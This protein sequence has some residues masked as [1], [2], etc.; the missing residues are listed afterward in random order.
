MALARENVVLTEIFGA[1]EGAMLRIKQVVLVI[2]GIAALAIAAKIKLPMWP[3]PATLQT[4]VVLSIGA[5]YGLRLGLITMLGYLALGVIG[6]DVFTGSSET[7]FGLSYMMGATGGYLVGFV[8]AAAVMG[9]LARKG[10]D[11]TAPKMA[12][13]MLIGNII[14]YAFGL[15]WMAYLFLEAK[16]MAWVMQ[17]GLTNFIVFDAVKLALAAM[18]FPALWAFVGKARD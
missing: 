7:S 2:L 12:L 14:I 15:P 10:W 3:V 5:S 6:F 13:S 11:R 16:G 1:S 17:W 4:F 9:V 8:V 18:M